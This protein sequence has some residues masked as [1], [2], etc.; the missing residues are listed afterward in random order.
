MSFELN[1]DFVP[2]KLEDFF[3]KQTRQNWVDLVP[4]TCLPPNSR[5]PK[6]A[7]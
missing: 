6:D 5:S 7:D 3:T 2:E 4:S 1:R